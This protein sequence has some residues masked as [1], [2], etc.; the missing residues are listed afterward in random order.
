MSVKNSMF[1]EMS[2]KLGLLASP[3]QPG[4]NDINKVADGST[5][6]SG[7]SPLEEVRRTAESLATDVVSNFIDSDKKKPP[8]KY[9]KT[10]RRTVKELSDRHDLVFK[11]MVNRLKTD[12]K[13]AFQTFVTVA[14]EIFDDGQINWGRT[15]AVYTFAARLAQHNQN[16]II[17]ASIQDKSKK[18]HTHSEKIAL[19]LGKYVASKLGQWILDQ[20]GWVCFL[21]MFFLAQ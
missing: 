11:A 16:T 15:V 14:D 10:L 12:E 19:F 13:N 8:N 17:N 7:N 9:C 6:T 2:R 1:T 18:S 20:G 21:F 5:Q 3:S 4:F